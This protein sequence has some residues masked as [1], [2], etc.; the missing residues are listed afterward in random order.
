MLSNKIPRVTLFV[1]CYNEEKYIIKTLNNLKEAILATNISHEIIVVDDCSRDKSPDLINK[2]IQN[3]SELIN[4]YL[5]ENECNKGLANNY[6][7]TALIAKG[8]YFRLICGDNA[9]DTVS[10]ITIF[11]SISKADIIVPYYT[12]VPGKEKSRILISYIYTGI[13]N[14]IT[15]NNI[16]YYNGCGVFITKDV[17]RWSPHSYGFGFQADLISRLISIGRT[18]YQVEIIPWHAKKHGSASPLHIR[19]LLSV[20]HTILELLIRRLKHLLF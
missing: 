1:A 14:L 13:I 2:F 9:E 20:I 6:I 8:E 16:K 17:V 3:N 19:N 4:I 11:N 12:Q 5:I 10:M 7:D 18:V 15:G